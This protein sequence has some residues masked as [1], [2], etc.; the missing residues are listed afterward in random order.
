MLKVAVPAPEASSTRS[1]CGEDCV[2][3]ARGTEA[4]QIFATSMVP[5]LFLRSDTQLAGLYLGT[6]T[7]SERVVGLA[8]S[9]VV[10]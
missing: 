5:T 3:G 2:P 6:H 10:G 4:A 8:T 1:S 9:L 7:V